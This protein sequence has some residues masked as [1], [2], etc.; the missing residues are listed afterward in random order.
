[1]HITFEFNGFYEVE[2]LM[3]SYFSTLKEMFK[4]HLL[5]DI[6]GENLKVS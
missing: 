6:L 4:E 3:N 2:C 5:Y 1:M